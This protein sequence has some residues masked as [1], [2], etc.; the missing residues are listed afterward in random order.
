[1]GIERTLAYA[2]LFNFYCVSLSVLEGLQGE[3]CIWRKEHSDWDVE[4]RMLTLKTGDRCRAISK[5]GCTWPT[6]PETKI[7]NWQDTWK[8]IVQRSKS[9]N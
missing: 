9:I 4:G 6:K 5:V 8:D 1:L 2:R 3:I 7:R